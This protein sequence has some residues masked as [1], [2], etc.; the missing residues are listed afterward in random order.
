[1][2]MAESQARLREMDEAAS[3]TTGIQTA[4]IGFG[5]TINQKLLEENRRAISE[6]GG[7]ADMLGLIQ[8]GRGMSSDQIGLMQ[9]MEGGTRNLGLSNLLERMP[10]SMSSGG[11]RGFGA[12]G[13]EKAELGRRARTAFADAEH[14]AKIIESTRATGFEQLEK[15][16]ESVRVFSS[17]KGLVGDSVL[18]ALGN[19]LRTAASKAGREGRKFGAAEWRKE[20]GAALHT[21]GLSE[22]DIANTLNSQPEF[23][24]KYAAAETRLT[25][26]ASAAAALE[27]VVDFDEERKQLSIKE[28]QIDLDKKREVTLATARQHGLLSVSSEYGQKGYRR[29]TDLEL[30]TQATTT[31]EQQ[32]IEALKQG[33]PEEKAATALFALQQTGTEEEKK[34]ATAAIDA[35]SKQGKGKLLDSARAR[36]GAMAKGP[37]L[38]TAAAFGREGLKTFKGDFGQ[39]TEAFKQGGLGKGI[40]DILGV[41][42]QTQAVLEEKGK[43]KW[44]VRDGKITPLS[45]AGGASDTTE[46]LTGLNQQMAALDQ[47]AGSLGAAGTKLNSAAELLI[48]AAKAGGGGSGIIDIIHDAA[49]RANQGPDAKGTTS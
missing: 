24:D 33:S 47:V 20:I 46:R 32:S 9:R 44:S 27:G 4:R 5:G 41:D 29:H 1:M 39:M 7:G 28:L 42:E 48:T 8:S 10:M 35:L 12:Y 21:Q 14:S 3:E 6:G 34:Q 23:W 13:A 38:K 49:M 30:L 25:G 15:A 26:D 17:K 45:G 2:N 22:K 37:G 36:A 43:G 31:E 40:Y 16:R 11:I 18:K 19:Q